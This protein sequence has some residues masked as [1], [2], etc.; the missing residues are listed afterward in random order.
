MAGAVG[1]KFL[2]GRC[3]PERKDKMENAIT[4]L[5]W[6]NGLFALCLL[7]EALLGDGSWFAAG[8]ALTSSV[9]TTLLAIHRQ[10]T[11]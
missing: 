2:L 8:F 6:A 7:A 10:R 4:A 9:A 11:E 3:G 1:C 5:C